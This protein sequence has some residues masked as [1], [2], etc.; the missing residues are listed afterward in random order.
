MWSERSAGVVFNKAAA[1]INA[2]YFKVLPNL[3]VS[4]KVAN[5]FNIALS[6]FGSIPGLIPTFSS[7]ISSFFLQIFCSLL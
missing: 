4:S 6:S 1:S 2:V 7:V 3:L 5:N